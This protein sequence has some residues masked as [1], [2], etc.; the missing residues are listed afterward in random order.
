MRKFAVASA[1]I[2]T[3]S[4]AYAQI[5][6]IPVFSQSLT[7]AAVGS[8]VVSYEVLP[9]Q[10]VSF[11]VSAENAT[12]AR[13]SPD[14]LRDGSFEDRRDGLA[15]T[16]ISPTSAKLKWG[17][18]GATD[19]WTCTT[20]DQT[21]DTLGGLWTISEAAN[22]IDFDQAITTA[23]VQLAGGY[24][25][26]GTPGSKVSLLLETGD[27]VA[28]LGTNQDL[29]TYS[30]GFTGWTENVNGG[31]GTITEGTTLEHTA[32]GSE[33]ILT[34]GSAHVDL[35]FTYTVTASTEY[36]VTFWA[37][38]A[39]SSDLCDFRVQ[40]STGGT[41][42]L[43]ADGTWD[44]AEVDFVTADATGTAYLQYTAKFTTDAGITG[45]D[46]F[47]SADVSGDVCGIDDTGI[48]LASASYIEQD[49]DPGRLFG[50]T[51]TADYVLGFIHQEADTNSI[52]EY[53]L[54]DNTPGVANAAYWTGSAW[55]AT[56]TWI[57]V[58]NNT[59]ATRVLDYF[60]ANAGVALPHQITL[61][62]RVYAAITEGDITLDDVFIVEASLAGDIGIDS[63]TS[64]QRD[65][66]IEFPYRGRVAVHDDGTGTTVIVTAHE[67]R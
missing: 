41:D 64:V 47:Y 38:A 34:G 61:S 62:F 32:G 2:L 1:L 37:R 55:S 5:L 31:T 27:M 52:L 54:R 49:T 65:I 40:E 8:S 18:R 45:I 13:F 30:G 46:L 26:D 51:G 12:T 23:Q 28:Q 58:T 9:Q 11:R 56:E 17:G 29:D 42:F 60:G 67:Q 35:S 48:T 25:A 57:Q 4:F 50:S 36:V 14:Y 19:N 10:V 20:C 33:A 53:Q 63:V 3:A 66:F 43:Q 59:S 44:A 39:D 16:P 21:D 7:A 24:P 6:G 15:T 22:D